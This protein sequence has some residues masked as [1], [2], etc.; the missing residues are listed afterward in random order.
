MQC[1]SLPDLSEGSKGTGR[2]LSGI[3]RGG[4]SSKRARPLKGSG[5][6]SQEAY[7]SIVTA[8]LTEKLDFLIRALSANPYSVGATG[9]YND[10]STK[11]KVVTAFGEVII[12]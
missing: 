12:K 9:A 4:G 8:P 1:Q 5:V 3:G 2:Q 10:P 6:Y 11:P 7:N